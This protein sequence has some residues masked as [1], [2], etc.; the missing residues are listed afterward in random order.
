M[1]QADLLF[2]S[3]EYHIA[4]LITPLRLSQT[5][6]ILNLYSSHSFLKRLLQ[7]QSK[8]ISEKFQTEQLIIGFENNC[9]RIVVPGTIAPRK[10]APARIIAPLIFAP[11]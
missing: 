8:W 6:I 1:Q 5:S 11:R 9:P 3:L 4:T 7:M 10:I 2:K